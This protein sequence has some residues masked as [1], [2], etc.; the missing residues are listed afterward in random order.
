ML[1][2]WRQ[3]VD[4]HCVV[5]D[6]AACTHDSLD[7]PCHRPRHIPIRILL[8]NHETWHQRDSLGSSN[9]EGVNAHVYGYDVFHLLKI[10][11]V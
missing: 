5:D 2:P 7:E 9:I 3:M 4:N 1:L 10:P 8:G 6:Q 11:H